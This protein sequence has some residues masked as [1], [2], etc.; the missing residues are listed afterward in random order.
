VGPGGGGVLYS[1]D[2]LFNLRGRLLHIE[3]DGPYI[4]DKTP[5][6]ETK[7]LEPK[8]LATFQTF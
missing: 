8:L 3:F 2:Y 4:H 7:T 5:S 6:E 1:D